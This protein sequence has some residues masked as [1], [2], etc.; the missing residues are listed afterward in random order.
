MAS[1]NVYITTFN[2]AREPLRCEDFASHLFDALPSEDIDALPDLLVLSLQELA[3]IAQSFLGGSFLTWYLERFRYAV[4]LATSRFGGKS[5]R[6]SNVV[7]RNVGMTAIMVFAKEEKA[8]AI[9]WVETAGVGVGAWGMGNKG[10]VGVRLGYD[11]AARGANAESEREVMEMTF[12]AAHL[13]PMEDQTDRRNEDWKNIVRGLVFTP[14]DRSTISPRRVGNATEEERPLLY[15]AI[16]NETRRYS[17]LYGSTSHVFLAGDL[18]Y[19]TQNRKPGPQ[20]HHAYPQPAEYNDDSRHYSY[21]FKDD[22]LSRELKAQKTCHGFTEA[23]VDFPPTY[24]YSNKQSEFRIDGEPQKWQW[25]KHRWPSWCD[26]ILFLVP[27]PA[28]GDIQTHQYTALPLMPTSDH[29][30][31]AISL[32]LP[33]KPIKRSDLTSD[34]PRA[35]SPFSI[36]PNW[37]ERREWARRR[38]IVVGAFAYLG[39]TWEGNGILLASAVGALGGWLL[40]RSLLD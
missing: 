11:A 22:Q 38:E 28:G 33:L 34:D 1:L 26:R 24:K 36:D 10:A 39:L 5:T 3:P 12:V 37:K 8:K 9:R 13:A 15:D 2:C 19:R 29:R 14:V 20:D 31:V 16:E 4:E 27:P 30:P 23:P 32:S 7:T 21:L 35:Q 17:G 25:A 6:Y 40:I 18:N